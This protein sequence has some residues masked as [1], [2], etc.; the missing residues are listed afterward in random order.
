[1]RRWL[2]AATLALPVSASAQSPRDIVARGLQAIGG[3]AAARATAAYQMDYYVLT[4]GLGQSETP[5]SPARATVTTGR[6]VLDW[7]QWRRF[8]AIETRGVTGAVTPQRIVALPDRGAGGGAA[9]T[10][11]M[12]AAA[13][14]NHQR[15]L[16]TNAHRLMLTAL[17]PGAQIAAVPAREFRGLT[18]D[19]VRLTG[20]DTVTM[21]FDRGT[22]MLTVLE[23]VADDPILGDRVTQTFVTRWHP[24]GPMLF[25]RQYDVF[26]NGVLQQHVIYAVVTPAAGVDSL[27][28]IPDSIANRQAPPPPAPQTTVRMVELGPGVWRAEGTSHHTLVVEQPDQIVLVEAPLSTQRMR[29]VIDTV[30]G[31]FPGKR[32]GMAVMTHYH[33]DH[34]S[35]IRE[36]VAEGIPVVTHEINAAFLRQVAAARRTQTPDLQAQRRRSPTLRTFTDSMVIGSGES[37][38]VLYRQPTVHAEGLITAWVPSAGVLFTSDVLNPAAGALPQP[39]SAELVALARARGLAPRSYAG[40]HGPLTPWADVERAAGR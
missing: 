21:Y 14:A 19:G 30:R 36:V 3:E 28:A 22:G 34:S 9:L 23:T 1:M 4:F 12:S 17:E 8:W 18:H 11:P 16:R 24:A 6:M 7:Q 25:P 32:I 5:A 37:R 39:A 38:L 31:R 35:G 13:V 20:A 33:W 10:A 26:V 2:L 40:G 27:F 29:A 15:F